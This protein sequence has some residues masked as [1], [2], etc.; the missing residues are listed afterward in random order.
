MSPY[1]VF[2]DPVLALHGGRIAAIEHQLQGE[3]VAQDIPIEQ[4][5][6]KQLLLRILGTVAGIPQIQQGLTVVQQ[7]LTG[8]QQG[9]TGVQ[10]GLAV[11]SI[12]I[13]NTPRRNHNMAIANDIVGLIPLAKETHATHD[14]DHPLGTMPPVGILPNPFTKAALNGLNGAGINVIRD[15]YG[16]APINGNVEARRT[17]LLRFFGVNMH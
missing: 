10:Q 8:V 5:T 12:K 2:V 7:G 15:F 13:E 4:L 11:N 17:A 3:E 6:V 16:L 14:G 1:C 9:L